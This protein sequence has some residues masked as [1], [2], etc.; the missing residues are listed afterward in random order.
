MLDKNLITS[1]LSKPD[2]TGN[3]FKSLEA[4]YKEAEEKE[5]KEMTER[6]ETI[7]EKLEK[8]FDDLDVKKCIEDEEKAI[9]KA[10]LDARDIQQ[11]ITEG[12]LERDFQGRLRRK[13]DDRDN[14]VEDASYVSTPHDITISS[15]IIS[16]TI[17]KCEGHR[18]DI[19]MPFGSKW[20][21]HSVIEITELTNRQLSRNSGDSHW[22]IESRNVYRVNVGDAIDALRSRGNNKDIPQNV[23]DILRVILRRNAKRISF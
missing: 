11:L 7:V 4:A 2:E 19:R 21:M 1:A 18:Y 13:S 6:E 8:A 14:W 10:E 23:K 9:E 16:R 22:Y 3:C 20:D 15:D 12:V 5:R 17:V